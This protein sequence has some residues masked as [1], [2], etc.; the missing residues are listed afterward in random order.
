VALSPD[1]QTLAFGLDDGT[2]GIYGYPSV[3][4]EGPAEEYGVLEGQTAE[5]NSV[6]FSPNGQ[7]VADTD[8]DGTA[9]IYFSGNP[10]MGSA[11]T[12]I[13]QC[14][15]GDYYPSGQFGWQHD[16]LV[17][18]V[19]TESNVISGPEGETVV[20]RWSMPSGRPLPGSVLLSSDGE[21]TCAVLSPNGR[22]AAVWNSTQATPR[23]RVMDL[24]SRR[25]ILTRPAM[26]IDGVVF[27]QDG[28]LLVIN[29][30]HGGL[31]TTTLSSDRTTVS[32]G[33]PTN[34]GPQ[35]GEEAPS[36]VAI[37]DNDRLEAVSS[38]CG[39]LRVGR[40][41]S[42]RPFETFLPHERLAGRIVFN[43]AGTRIALGVSD[44]TATVMSV[45]TDRTVLELIGDT[46]YVSDV[47][48]S[49]VGNLMATTS[50][51]DTLRI[52]N[53]STGQLLRTDYDS[54]FTQLPMF[55]PDGR[56]VAEVNLWWSLHVWP[57]CPDCQDSSALLAASRSSIVPHITTVERASVVAAGG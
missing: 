47:T 50:E 45:A 30:G 20:R 18:I 3:S 56:Y 27:S 14:G 24:A 25:V 32:H 15:D 33:W 2:G 28:R 19:D 10:W 53:A 52:W 31:H 42:P 55:S 46:R 22:M 40:T 16:D 26:P 35:E 29:D 23:V 8:D 5:V 9:R 12:L 11:N 21:A 17:G 37:S 36:G 38:F 4:G 51:D 48:F 7:R 1:G 54:S 39:V 57:A 34:C 44:S 13:E 41:G 49:P 6:V 43:P